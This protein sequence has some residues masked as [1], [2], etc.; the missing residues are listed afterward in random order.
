MDREM[1]NE[2]SRNEVDCA[3]TQIRKQLSSTDI[4]L[5][6]TDIEVDVSNA[7]KLP[8]DQIPALGVALGSLPEAFRT[9]TATFDVPTLLQATDEFGHPLDPSI[10][11]HFNDGSG[12]LGSFRDPING[13]SQARLHPVELGSITN[14]MTI[15]YDP[16][17]L[18]IA[19]ALSQINQKLDAIQDTVNEMFEYMKQKDKAELRGNIRVLESTLEAYR[20]NWNNDIWR[21]TAHTKVE[22][23]KQESEK[24]IIHLRSQIRTKLAEKGPIE[25]RVNVD[26]RLNE[27]LDRLKEYQLAVYTYSFAS[28]LEP[29]L[30]E[31][32]SEN[33][34]T[35]IAS[36]ISDHGIEYR[37]L[38][39]DCYDAIEKNAQESID[40]VALNGVA[41]ALTGLGSLIKQ[42]PI[43]QFTPI[44]EA[45]ED[46]GKGVG[47]FNSEQT[48]ALMEKLAHAK[49]PNISP[50]RESIEAV[51]NLHNKP[52]QIIADK[53]NIYLLPLEEQNT[54]EQ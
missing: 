24:A 40:A 49:A 35:N 8:F 42:T 4:R 19:A 32:Y 31:N 41:S 43:G 26:N 21:N 7:I 27:I 34:L 45:L 37:E 47:G 52:Q 23:I 14:V 53:D 33:N 16:T 13:F 11:Q 30:C 54:N 44:D 28:F 3:K 18:F 48:Q 36:K 39:T 1:N 15:P 46:A 29:M 51:N 25:I 50:F 17:S 20:D 12:L 6:S 9:V 10:L 5:A 38:Y 22:D 2:I